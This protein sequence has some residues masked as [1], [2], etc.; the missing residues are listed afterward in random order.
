MNIL[1]IY[2]FYNQKELM[3][4]FSLRLAENGIFA[5]VLC[6]NNF[7]Y[8]KHT[9]LKWPAWLMKCFDWGESVRPKWLTRYTDY[10]LHRFV[11]PRLFSK[12]DL[13][14]FHAYYPS[15][16]HLMQTCV[17]KNFRFD[18]TLWGSELM[19][20]TAERK[21]LLKYGFD[22]AC[23]VKMTDNLHDVL[24]ESYG[25]V[26]EE[27]SR[28]VYFGNSEIFHIENLSDENAKEIRDRL[29]GNTTDKMIV[30]LGYNGL[31][32]QNH[33]RMIEAAAS[34]T[35][36]LKQSLHLVLPMTYCSS[37]EYIGEMKP[38][39]DSSSI[40]YTILDH[41]LDAKEVAAIRKTAHVVVNVQDS[42]ALSASLNGHLFCGNVCIFG[43]WLKYGV[44][45]DNDIY[46]IKTS[47]EDIA[48]H[49]KDV[50]EHYDRYRQLCAGNH[51]KIKDLFSW[52]ATMKKQIEAYGE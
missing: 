10:I 29:Y 37:P 6:Y 18:I 45:T 48:S 9:L 25:E 20:G 2:P 51:D 12:Y 41:F 4:N 19:R 16:N 38:L 5:D 31:S 33:R 44:Y 47:M 34:L 11:I 14:D 21:R 15:Y 8:E 49:L 27:K 40:S 35:D 17:K 30:V 50:L 22:N 1:I 3:H 13:I 26:Y 23:R 39:L 32:A 28:I 7:R 24:V 46:Y 42:D 43:E 52:E 36:S